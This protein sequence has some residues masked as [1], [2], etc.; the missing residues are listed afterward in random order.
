M[1]LRVG[2]Q[3]QKSKQTLPIA[4]TLLA[5]VLLG[6]L[7]LGV[8]P[9]IGGGGVEAAGAYQVTPEPDPCGAPIARVRYDAVNVR[10]GPDPSYRI[11]AVVQMGTQ[12]PVTGR[13]HEFRWWAVTLSDGRTGWMWDESVELSGDIASA[14][15]LPAPG[16]ED[17]VPDAP[18]EWQP[19]PETPCL[20]SDAESENN[21]V[22]AAEA[23]AE[24]APIEEELN[25]L[26]QGW[27]APHNLSRSGG[28]SH[29]LL[30]IGP[31]QNPHVLWN[32]NFV[33]ALYQRRDD[34]GWATP[35][36]V[37]V[38]LTTTEAQVFF[39]RAGRMHAVWRDE[40]EPLQYSRTTEAA[41]TATGL[42]TEPVELDEAALHVR[43]AVDRNGN[44]HLVY[45]R[46]LD[47]PRRPAGVYYQRSADGGESWSPPVALYTSPYLRGVGLSDSNL[48]I[49]TGGEISERIYV[50]WDNRAQKR[51]YLAR[52]H[53]GG[54]NWQ[55]PEEVVGPD[56][57]SSVILPF[58]V[59]I[60]ARGN[61]LLL[62]WQ[63]G[64]P[65]GQC[66]RFSRWS[67]D[68]GTTWGETQRLVDL[69]PG[70]AS[71]ALENKPLAGEEL[72]FLWTA[73]EN[74]IF[75]QAWNGREWSQPQQQTLFS[76]FNDPETMNTVV[77]DCFQT[78]VVDGE[79]LLV[80]TCGSAGSP[81]N[82]DIWFTERSLDTAVEWFPPPS[83]WSA[84]VVVDATTREYA[85]LNLF[86]DGEGGVHALWSRIGEGEGMIYYSRR[87]R[88]RWLAPVTL[89]AESSAPEGPLATAMGPGPRLFAAW[90][91]VQ[92][93]VQF[94]HAAA[95]EAAIVQEWAPL[96]ALRVAPTRVEELALAVDAMGVVYVAYTVPVNEGRGVYYVWSQD[97]GS[98]WSEP[99]HVLDGEAWNW[100]VVG[101]LEMGVSGSGSLHFLLVEQILGPHGGR[102][103]AALHYVRCTE[104]GGACSEP[105]RMGTNQPLWQGL[106]GVGSETLHR[107]WQEQ[108]GD[109]I[110]LYH[111]YSGDDGASWTPA[112]EVI[113]VT[114]A[115][116]VWVG[117]DAAGALRVVQVEEQLL[118]D[119]VWQGD[120]WRRDEAVALEAA[121]PLQGSV[122]AS[123]MLTLLFASD[124][125]TDE[126]L[127]AAASE[128]H[129]AAEQAA[130]TQ[131]LLAMS[132]QLEVG[133]PLPLPTPHPAGAATAPPSE[134]PASA[135]SPTATLVP[136]L[137]GQGG[138]EQGPAAARGAAN[139]VFQIGV[140]VL[141][142]L[143]LLV[144]VIV[145]GTRSLWLRQR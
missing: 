67:T 134:A 144:G 122:A 32:D 28:T 61:Q 76:G 24:S 41:G 101:P 108:D 66:R 42:W 48:Q 112:Q 10:L 99:I 12:L 82:S 93:S 29:P 59:Q 2:S 78:A 85:D 127:S 92:G 111:S 1:I 38:P 110:F 70:F 46:S 60:A 55:A 74:E 17:S 3:L 22:V 116:P 123:G 27:T 57:T 21:I 71:C 31:R 53:D 126:G 77:F 68:G 107:L 34:E 135:V 18:P 63:R 97:G 58:N 105:E 69:N 141:P 52:S 9:A 33:G 103:A 49:V 106:A 142:A 14:P 15:L 89:F 83:A 131:E 19:V 118:T 94:S 43:S 143:L 113:G 115:G 4:T 145:L 124:I 88:E 79:R 133:E 62:V 11:L 20:D 5:A 7:L 75:L 95:D 138:A 39:D 130:A 136:P 121:S 86:S 84:P 120:G 44:L 26:E 104:R 139:A 98:T 16:Q 56:S 6:V 65:E 40:A 45:I 80:A 109:L 81:G 117:A 132:R 119:W 25:V 73:M 54:T 114:E 100:E 72:F 129:Q 8:W 47:G 35:L 30:L 137:T 102:E 96:R 90:R 37:T 36:T 51:L 125:A 23:T 64:Q 128:D 87:E 140:G 13:H 91:D 50:A